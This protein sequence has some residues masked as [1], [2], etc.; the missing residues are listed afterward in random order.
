MFSK[1]NFGFTIVEL[2]VTIAVLGLLTPVVL[3]TLGDYYNDNLNSLTVSTQDADVRAA[4]ATISNDLQETRGFSTTFNV[5]TTSPLG[6]NNGNSD[7]SYCGLNSSTTACDGDQQYNGNE[8]RVL[9]TYGELSDGPASSDK[10]F[11]I[12]ID[13]GNSWTTASFATAK[14]AM[15]AYIYFV[16]PDQNNPAQNN[17]YRRTISYTDPSSPDTY[18]GNTGLRPCN[19]TNPNPSGCQ[20]PYQKT[21]CASSVNFSL[22]S[23]CKASDA[24]LLYNIQSFW[25][26]YY[27]SSNNPISAYANSTDA[28]QT[29]AIKNAKSAKITI[30]KQM[31]NLSK[32]KT[33]A[34]TLVV[35]Q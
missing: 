10:R 27:D 2:I 14:T 34:S 24:V 15:F 4:L 11:P 30:S 19:T 18:V 16:A 32:T 33:T 7:W 29:S 21:T 6:S 9:I 31:S 13:D 17:L 35:K 20:D 3:N 26:D 23:V 28:N 25:I 22:Y 1:K 12:F 8:K 5:A